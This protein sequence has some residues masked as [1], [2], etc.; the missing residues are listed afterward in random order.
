M[1]VGGLAGREG[2]ESRQ[3]G[4]RGPPKPTP[5]LPYL[6]TS[7]SSRETEGPLSKSGP[8]VEG[9]K[10]ATASAPRPWPSTTSFPHRA[11]KMR[12]RA[13]TCRLRGSPRLRSPQK[14]SVIHCGFSAHSS[15]EKPQRLPGLFFPP[16]PTPFLLCAQSL[17]HLPHNWTV[18]IMNTEA[19]D[20]ASPS[21][22][23]LFRG[24]HGHNS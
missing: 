11:K 3:V 2:Y 9:Q 23:P 12:I 13:L 4:N 14:V 24:G 20:M 16:L 10:Y 22:E 19:P 8:G 21:L 6:P 18:N 7:C 1:A 15:A 5:L 17:T